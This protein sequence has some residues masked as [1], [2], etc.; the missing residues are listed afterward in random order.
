MFSFADTGNMKSLAVLSAYNLSEYAFKKFDNGTV[1][2]AEACR[3]AAALPGCKKLL[4]L[5][6]QTEKS[7]IESFLKEA[8]CAEAEYA[9][10]DLSECTAH[11]VFSEAAECA[12]RDS[13][14]SNVFF[15]Q[16]DTP[17]IDLKLARELF[18]RHTEYRAEYSFTDGYPAGLAP[19][20]VNAGLCSILSKVSEEDR[21]E[22]GKTFLFDTVKKEINNYDIET[23]IAPHDLR[24][25]RLNFAADCKRNFLL[26]GRF[27]DIDSENYA[28]L[29]SLRGEMLFTLP[30]YY[31][32]EVMP[33]HP[34]QSIYKPVQKA[35]KPPMDK[36]AFF[37][38]IEKIVDFSQDAVI[39]LSV[40]GEPVLYPHLEAVTEKI[41][42]YPK[43][44][45]LIETSGLCAENGLAE[46]IAAIVKKAP[47]RENRMEAVYWIVNIDAV[48]SP[49]YAKVHGLSEEEAAAKLKQ[50]VTFTDA[51]HKLFPSAVWAQII[52][53]NENEAETEPFYRFWKDLGI[54]VIIQKFDTF[55]KTLDDKRV[56]D[57]SPFERRPCWHIKRDMYILNDGTV[58]LCREDIFCKHVLGNAFS[59][60][61]EALREKAFAVYKEHLNCKY[62]G[63][64]EFCDE[65]YTFNF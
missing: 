55:C 24:Y 18:D 3:K 59:D 56:A 32:I 39:S 46:K 47:P 53:M 37:S 52:R 28:E 15:L 60:S 12:A 43:L 2:F 42:S 38:L 45:V 21:A 8:N 31:G 27:T 22:A 5:T 7:G 14:I 17:F 11:A 10:R 62:G 36:D 63:L 6:T 23:V 29:I 4:I 1:P 26:C 49:M 61:L 30:A 13:E 40:L 25:L 57:L 33:N 58:P 44:S 54:N 16:A 64:C 50:A 35:G 65:Y 20:V 48:S 9:V 51:A 19:E 41:L 34:L